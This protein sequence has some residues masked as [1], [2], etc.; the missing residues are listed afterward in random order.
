ML[1]PLRT[2]QHIPRVYCG[3]QQT[4]LNKGSADCGVIAVGGE[5]IDKNIQTA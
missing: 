5:I 3:L 4:L 1:G 2:G